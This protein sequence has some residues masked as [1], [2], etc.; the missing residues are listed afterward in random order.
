LGNL[1]FE[2]IFLIIST[3]LFIEFIF[4]I[5]T[6]A[7]SRETTGTILDKKSKTFHWGSVIGITETYSIKFLNTENNLETTMCHHTFD[8][9]TLLLNNDKNYNIGSEV[10]LLI[11]NRKKLVV[12]IK[13]YLFAQII[14]LIVLSLVFFLLFLCYFR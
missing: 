14:S 11:A 8:L 5:I 2:I 6:Y 12:Y 10:N 1:V 3:L 9:I 4:Q 13:P 7:T